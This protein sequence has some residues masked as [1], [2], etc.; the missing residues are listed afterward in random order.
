MGKDWKSHES[1]KIS[2]SE[3]FR[4]ILWCK[5]IGKVVNR[6]KSDVPSHFEPLQW[7][8]IGK[9]VNHIKLG[10]LNYSVPLQ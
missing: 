4:A 7:K 9:I 10:I 3:S 6:V 1:V 5:K 8:R 2:S